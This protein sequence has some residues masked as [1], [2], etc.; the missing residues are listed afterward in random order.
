MTELTEI[1]QKRLNELTDFLNHCPITKGD[2]ELKEWDG[3]MV[4]KHGKGYNV[5]NV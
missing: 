1:E 2:A 3:L 4:K 5:G